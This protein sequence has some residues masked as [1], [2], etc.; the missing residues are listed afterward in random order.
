MNVSRTPDAPGEPAP[1]HAGG[2][3]VRGAGE[4]RRYLI[5]RATRNREHWVLPKGH[6]EPGETPVQAA[7]REVR[8]ETGVEGEIGA[9]LG[10]SAYAFGGEDVRVAWFLVRSLRE[11]AP[12]EPRERRWC[13]A[14]E[15]QRLLSFDD[16][17]ELVRRAHAR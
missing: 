5:V 17:R 8:E 7:L 4:T 6:I 10:E 2:V 15:A 9:P 14:T 13:D 11:L 1:T 12:L 3:V 16:A